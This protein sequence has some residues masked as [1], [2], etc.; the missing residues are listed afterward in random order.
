MKRIILALAILCLFLGSAGQA[1]ADFIYWTDQTPRGDIRRANLDEAG[2]QILLTG[3]NE[4]TGIALDLKSTNKMYWTDQ[5][6][7]GDIRRANLDGTGQ[8]DP[9]ETFAP[10][11]IALDLSGDKMYWTDGSGRGHPKGQP[12]RLGAAGSRERPE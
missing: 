8:A 5:S 1:Y 9:L 2:Q 4:P 3:Q 10:Y 6:P 11:G 12:R 7:L